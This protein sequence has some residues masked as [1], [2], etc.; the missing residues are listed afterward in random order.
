MAAIVALACPASGEARAYP[1]PLRTVTV[2]NA[3]GLQAA[4]ERA[5][6]GDHIVAADGVYQT[7]EALTLRHSGTARR[8]IVIRAANRGKATITGKAGLLLD[9]ADHAIVAGFVFEGEIGTAVKLYGCSHSRVTRNHIRLRERVNGPKM[10]WVISKY[11]GERNRIDH[12]LLEEKRAHGRFVYIHYHRRHDRVDHNHFR[13]HSPEGDNGKESIVVRGYFTIVEDNLFENCSGE[14]E[15]ISVKS[16][17]P[18]RP[19]GGNAP[20]VNT[21]RYNAFLDSIG[22][23]CLRQANRCLVEGNHFIARGGP[24]YTGGVK[25]YGD[26]HVIRGNYFEGLTGDGHYAPFV[27]MHGDADIDYDIAPERYLEGMPSDIIMFPRPNRVQVSHNTWVNCS[28]LELGWEA[29]TSRPLT[30]RDC[31]FGNNAIVGSDGRLVKVMPGQIDLRL[32]GNVVQARGEAES[33]VSWFPVSEFRAG[34]PGKYPPTLLQ[35]MPTIAPNGGTFTDP[36]T[37]ALALTLDSQIRYTLD[38]TWPTQSSA[39]YKGPFTLTKSA[40]VRARAFS[41]GEPGF[42]AKARFTIMAHQAPGDPGGVVNG[43]EYEFYEDEEK[44][45]WS[46]P[47]FDALT[48]VRSGTV[49]DFGIEVAEGAEHFAIR[50]GGF[51]SIPRDGVY[52][53]SKRSNGGCRLCIGSVLV[54]DNDGLYPHSGGW[55][56]SGSIALRAGRHAMT[57]TCFERDYPRRLELHYSGPGIEE[58]RVPASALYRRAGQA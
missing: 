43:L 53:F 6:P 36:V 55:G 26:D 7:S 17:Y 18:E 31:T 48:P 49:D 35:R 25:V 9:G 19:A 51:I 50:F 46:L 5:R 27:F 12:N 34:E 21:F 42:E 3:A 10:D 38:D 28:T 40:T 37:V 57:L 39:L 58:Q 33:G 8:T 1:T 2:A 16:I 56:R 11:D 45:W 15:I 44:Q 41:G 14:G 32:G 30:T 22:T 13:D 4:L 47:D 24:G 52:T 54:L 23:L 29:D 20:P